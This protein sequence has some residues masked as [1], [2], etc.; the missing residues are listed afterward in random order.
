MQ[1]VS[2]AISQ[3]IKKQS[4]FQTSRLFH[5]MA[6]FLNLQMKFISTGGPRIVLFLR[7]QE[8]VL[9]RK[10]YYL[11]TDLVLKLLFMTFGFSKS[12]YFAHFQAVLIFETKKLIVWF[13]LKHLLSYLSQS[14]ASLQDFRQFLTYK[15]IYIA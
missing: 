9:L 6:Q 10:L 2:L 5:F 4:E 7:P 8:T 13:D 3:I 11:G 12:P 1:Y 14:L 15:S